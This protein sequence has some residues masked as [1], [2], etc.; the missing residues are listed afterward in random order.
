MLA[1]Q[2][3]EELDDTFCGPASAAMVLNAV[4]ARSGNLPKDMSRLHP[5]DLKYLPP[6]VDPI[7][8]RYTQDNVLV[9]SPKTR[10]QVL[11]EPMTVNGKEVVRDYGFHVRQLDALLRANGLSTTLV[12]VDYA[13][14]EQD[15]RADLIENLE[16]PGDYVIVSYLR[17]AVASTV[18]DIFLRSA[19]TTRN[20]I[21][22]SFST[23]IRR[24]RDGCGC[25]S[26]P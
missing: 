21:R 26:R 23:S 22:S 12:I 4:N 14:S 18:G 2:Y 16:R 15:I 1:N 5:D 20:P 6:G 19:H 9:K 3:E 24:A 8:P 17:D 13:K 25:Q 11:G 10:A 7:I